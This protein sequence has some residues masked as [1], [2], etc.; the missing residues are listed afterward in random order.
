MDKELSFKQYYSVSETRTIAT[1]LYSGPRSGRSYI[2][3]SHEILCCMRYGV[4]LVAVCRAHH[5]DIHH[6]SGVGISHAL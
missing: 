1:A 2:E 3:A 5:S 6:P 4:K